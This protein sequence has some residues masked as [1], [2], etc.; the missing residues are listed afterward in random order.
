MRHATRKRRLSR[1]TDHRNSLLNNLAKSLIRHGQIRTT[2]AK[3]KEAQRLTDRLVNL[4][5]EGS[6]HAR[7]Q[8]FRVLQDQGL[9][10]QLFAEIAPRFLDSPGGY[11]RVVR[12]SHRHGDG[13][14]EAILAFS[15]LGAIER[16][17]SKPSPKSP[18]HPKIPTAT[19]QEP[20]H[21]PQGPADKPKGF[22]EGLRTLWTRKKT[23]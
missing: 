5:K 12:L 1:P 9:V 22:F 23:R 19:P 11:S 10:K 18:L 20:S 8:A 2:F 15:R 4:G 17:V 21:Q 16:A 6:V 14:P 3:A 7:R 13:A